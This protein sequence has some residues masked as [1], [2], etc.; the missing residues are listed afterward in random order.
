MHPPIINYKIILTALNISINNCLSF[1][2]NYSYLKEI[3]SFKDNSFIDQPKQPIYTVHHRLSLDKVRKFERM[4]GDFL[5]RPRR[6][7]RG[8]DRRNRKSKSGR[9]PLLVDEAR[10]VETSEARGE[11]GTGEPRVEGHAHR[12]RERAMVI[13]FMLRRANIYIV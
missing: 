3:V 9:G 13:S 10:G 7:G 8:R 11:R 1:L 12:T 6:R 5:M 2:S 4:N